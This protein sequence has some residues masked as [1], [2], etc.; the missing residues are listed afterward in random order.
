MAYLHSLIGGCGV[1]CC[2]C[3]NVFVW[4]QIQT[5]IKTQMIARKRGSGIKT[6][7]VRVKRRESEKL[8]DEPGEKKVL[9]LKQDTSRILHTSKKREKREE[10]RR[11][12]EE[13]RDKGKRNRAVS[14]TSGNFVV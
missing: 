9:L 11:M 10:R 7:R 2:M 4:Y 1:C 12:R 14:R 3:V 13:N 8:K 6:I 5:V